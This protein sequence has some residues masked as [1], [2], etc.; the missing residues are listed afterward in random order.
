MKR[1]YMVFDGELFVMRLL[2]TALLGLCCISGVHAAGI[3][4]E[5][6]KEQFSY[7]IGVQIGQSLVRQGVL[8]DADAF[9]LAVRD[10]LD[11]SKPRLSGA[12]MEQALKKGE[13]DVSSTLLERAKANLASGKKFLAENK[14]KDDVVALSSG[15][16]Y[17]II[18][19]GPG[20]FPKSNSTVMVHY[21]GSLIDGREFDSSRR[22]SEAAKLNLAKVIKGWQEAIPLMRVGSRWQIFVPASLAYGPRGAGA[23]IGPNETLIFEIELLEIVE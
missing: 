19:S 1:K 2:S 6:E 17:K 23:V 13:S 5:T 8:L 22:R 18:R 21:T 20:E 4:L 10:A 16:Q 7:A 12:Q 15:L 9:N 11:G 3:S 14:D